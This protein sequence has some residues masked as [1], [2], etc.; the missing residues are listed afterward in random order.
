MLAQCLLRQRNSCLASRPGAPL[1]AE[2]PTASD[3]ATDRPH[4]PAGPTAQR[5]NGG[6][7]GAPAAHGLQLADGR[8]D[9]P[10]VAVDDIEAANAACDAVSRT[11]SDS[12]HGVG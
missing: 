3:N 10:V 12:P 4:H 11:D 2:G 6:R 8:A 5:P 1:L 7:S 9:Q